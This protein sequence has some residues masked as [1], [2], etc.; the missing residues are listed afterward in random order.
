ME[1]PL[2]KTEPT[3]KDKPMCQLNIDRDHN[4]TFCWSV[5]EM[6]EDDIE[7]W[8]DLETGYAGR[9]RL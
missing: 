2:P 3:H 5:W 6:D 4:G 7:Y 1:T 8:H 9:E